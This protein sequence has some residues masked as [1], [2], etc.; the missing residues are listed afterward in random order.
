MPPLEN[1]HC[2]LSSP[3]LYSIIEGNGRKNE[4]IATAFFDASGGDIAVI[5]QRQI[6]LGTS[7]FVDAEPSI[8][9]EGYRENKTQQKKNG[10][11]WLAEFFGCTC[12]LLDARNADSPV[13]NFTATKQPENLPGKVAYPIAVYTDRLNSPALVERRRRSLVKHLTFRPVRHDSE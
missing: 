4:E 11:E 3:V 1:T 5:A 2:H 12:I 9:Q 8:I 13:R 6:S 10:M 7:P